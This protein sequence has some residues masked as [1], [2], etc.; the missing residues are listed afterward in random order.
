MGE[1]WSFA[2]I[3]ELCLHSLP[4]QGHLNEDEHRPQSCIFYVQQLNLTYKFLSKSI[5]SAKRPPS[6]HKM[7]YMHIR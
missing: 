7:M 4:T 3:A 2:H 5:V 6:Q 1:V